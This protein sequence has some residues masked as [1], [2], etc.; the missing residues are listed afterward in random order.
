M[1]D[2]LP[3]DER[4]QMLR[5]W[6]A[7]WVQRIDT[8]LAARRQRWAE[9]EYGRRNRPA[10]PECLVELGTGTRHP[11]GQVHAGNCYTVGQRRRAVDRDEARRLLAAGLRACGH[12][13]PDVELD[14]IG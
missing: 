6:H 4:L 14:V 9:E 10:P 3:D 5:I 8:K 12:C 13:Q 11:P 2:D 1:L 7:M